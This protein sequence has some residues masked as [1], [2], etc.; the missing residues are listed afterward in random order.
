MQQTL[1]ELSRTSMADMFYADA[2]QRYL[3]PVT[4]TST[5]LESAKSPAVVKQPELPN[6]SKLVRPSDYPVAQLKGSKEIH[7]NHWNRGCGERMLGFI[8]SLDLVGSEIARMWA[9][10]EKKLSDRKRLWIIYFLGRTI[11]LEG[12]IGAGKSTLC[13]II[14][15][16]FQL[17]GI[18]VKMYLE[19]KNEAYLTL[20]KSN[21]T[22]HAFGFQ[23]YMLTQR[24]LSTSNGI[25][26]NQTDPAV[27]IFDRSLLG[28]RSFEV[29]HVKYGN[30]SPEEH[31]AYESV[32]SQASTVVPP[33]DFLVKLEVNPDICNERTT[34]RG[35]VDAGA[36]NREYY[37]NLD[38]EY[39][40]LYT[41]TKAS[42]NG[43]V[44][45]TVNH[46]DH[47]SHF[48][49]FAKSYARSQSIDWED[50]NTYL[51]ISDAIG[52]LD[53]LLSQKLNW[54]NKCLL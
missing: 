28:D 31:K 24:I 33:P 53:E 23:M 3:E 10:L 41:R 27:M 44:C 45:Y 35:D 26:S 21:M 17:A 39:E 8:A 34:E 36:Y 50:I 47:L 42:N 54:T 49:E 30:I 12:L 11:Y 7:K 22:Q 14:N 37:V 46:D 4:G 9:E 2:P 5:R 40:K 52:I 15:A 29:M 48:A 43:T 13:K 1:V 51:C 16:T 18:N 38:D 25:L 20:F 32:V 19:H 6:V